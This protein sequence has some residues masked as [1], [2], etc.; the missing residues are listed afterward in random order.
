MGNDAS[1]DI[2]GLDE[3]ET[4]REGKISCICSALQKTVN[5]IILQ[6]TIATT[7]AMIASGI[8]SLGIW[9]TEIYDAKYWHNL[10]NRLS[11]CLQEM[12]VSS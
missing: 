4:G 7:I 9:Q 12:A 11:H 3:P 6:R 8:I 5:S 1:R 10:S 2:V